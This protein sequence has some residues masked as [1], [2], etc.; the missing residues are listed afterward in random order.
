MFPNIEAGN[1]FFFVGAD[2]HEQAD[3][4]KDDE[5]SDDSQHIGDDRRNELGYQ[6]V[7][8]AVEEAVGTGRIDV[9]RRPEPRC[10]GAPSTADAVNPE[11]IEGIVIAEASLDDGDSDVADD[12]SNRTDEKGRKRSDEAGCPG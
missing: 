8:A 5:G 4:F 10:E 9:C 7:T 2:R 1:F 12:T 6:Q 3:D 11:G